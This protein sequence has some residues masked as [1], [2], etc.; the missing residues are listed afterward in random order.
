MSDDAALWKLA[1][2]ALILAICGLTV[3]LRKAPAAPAHPAVVAQPA[4]PAAA[5]PPAEPAPQPAAQHEAAPPRLQIV[6]EEARDETSEDAA[7][8]EVRDQARDEVRD[9]PRAPAPR[10][11]PRR[12][13]QRVMIVASRPHIRVRRARPVLVQR[14]ASAQPQYPFE[15]SERWNPRF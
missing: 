12:R 15:P 6:M 8:D 11:K 10:A 4:A 13:A 7:R 14:V 2:G 5:A 3:A 1:F 9:Q